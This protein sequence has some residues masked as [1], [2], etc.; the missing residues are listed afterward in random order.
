MRRGA[1][2]RVASRR[3]FRFF[4]L[5]RASSR[6]AFSAQIR[7]IRFTDYLRLETGLREDTG[8]ILSPCERAA[9]R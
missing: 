7:R 5:T 4:S 6:L 1:T 3:I 2:R 8:D 9:E